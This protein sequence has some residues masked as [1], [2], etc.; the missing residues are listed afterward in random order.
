MSTADSNVTKEK[1]KRKQLST[2]IEIFRSPT[3]IGLYITIIFLLITSNF[4]KVRDQNVEERF[5]NNPIRNQLYEVVEWFDLKSMDMRFKIRGEIPPSN[6]VALLTVDDRSIEEIGRWPWSREKIAFVVDEMMKYGAKSIGFDIVFAEKQVDQTFETL[7][8]LEKAGGPLPLELQKAFEHEKSKGQPDQILAGMLA[9]YGDHLVLGAFNDDS[10]Q[11]LNPYQDYC[12][13]EAFLRANAD[14]FVRMGNTTFVVNDL[15]DPFVE[16]EF[17][18]VFSIIFPFIKKISTE[19]ALKQIFAKENVTELNERENAQL[20]FHIEQKQMEY[21]TEWLTKGD[22]YFEQLK[23]VYEEMFAKS[24]DLKGMPLDQ[25]VSKFKKMVKPSPIVQ[26]Q[27]WTIN[28]DQI[29]KAAQYTGSFNAEQDSDGTIRRASMFFRTGNRFGLSFIPSIALQTY[30]ISTGYRADIDIDT[31]PKHPEQKIITQFKIVD[32]K[33]EPEKI[34]R[35]VPVDEQGRMKINYAGGRNMYPYVAARELFNGKDTMTVSQA[36]WFPE[37]KVWSTREKVVKKAEFLKDRAFIFG[38]TAVGVYDLRVTPYDKNFP[39]PETHVN[40]LGNL[41]EGNFIKVHPK[42]DI[43]MLVAIAI[44]GILIS[45]AIAHTTA[46]PGFLIVFGSLAALAVIDQLIFKKGMIATGTL[47]AGLVVFLYV[48]LFFYKYLTEERK[49]K[50]LKNTFS[51]YVSPAIVEEIL[52]DPENIELGGKRVRLAVFFSDLRNFTTI[53]EKLQATELSDVLNLY[54]TPMTNIV[55]ENKGTLDKYIGDAVMAFFGAPINFNDNSQWACRCAILSIKKLDS[56]R[57]DIDQKFPGKNIPIAIGIGIN[58]ADVSAGNMGSDI[59]RSY[60][61]MGDGVNL[62]SRLEGITKE[63]GVQI[64][65]SQFTYDDVKDMFTCRELDLVRVKGK[66]EPIR[67]YELISEGKPDSQTLQ[68]IQHFSEGY[69]L[70]HKK[71]FAA[72]KVCFQKA[73]EVRPEDAPS[74]LYIERCDDFMAE[75]PPVDWD[76]VKVMKT[77]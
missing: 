11:S 42:E 69:G 58:T 12:R 22:Q 59:V 57:K 76:G 70:Y 68:V 53:S 43:Y 72:A 38:A 14:K 44:L 30:L 49:K 3:A 8:R 62:A 31:D 32:P 28:T 29:E 33:A 40:V 24:K 61:V 65:I 41:F 54:L 4:Y 47:P 51:K 10:A 75:P 13:N 37:Q 74:A 64:V 48:F 66:L 73:L 46:I 15:A 55:F 67:I 60:T 34:M 45:A 21:C 17:D 36:E 77:K 19:T 5:A 16:I 18:K 39:G 7:T 63:Y 25:A 23:K 52:K 20:K 50:Y 9:K 35:Q 71:D 6:N 56:I 27:R 1:K 2:V 26:Q